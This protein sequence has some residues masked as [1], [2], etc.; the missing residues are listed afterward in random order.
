MAYSPA[1]IRGSRF[2]IRVRGYQTEAVE[3]FLAR[4]AA[5]Y[6][7]ALDAT[8]LVT[9][10]DHY[11]MGLSTFLRELRESAENEIRDAEREARR[12]TQQ[13][14]EK[15]AH[16]QD[17]AD[18]EAV[19]IRDS[20]TRAATT[21][22]AEAELFSQSAVSEAREVRERVH[23]EVARMRD[24]ATQECEA[25]SAS[26]RELA[27]KLLRDAESHAQELVERTQKEAERLHNDTMRQLAALQSY[28]RGSTERIHHMQTLLKRFTHLVQDAAPQAL[29]LEHDA[30]HIKDGKRFSFLE[31]R[32]V[33]LAT[34]ATL[35]TAPAQH[36]VDVFA[37]LLRDLGYMLN[38]VV[39]RK[40]RA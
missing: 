20:A 33:Q 19:A 2:P 29:A 18:E 28:E 16:I 31:P 12:A 39:A 22:L 32:E 7:L 9:Q 17:Q 23:L 11:L 34:I 5:D 6:Q 40:Q 24:R 37:A 30:V 26:A 15:V 14:V 4:L 21:L 8:S 1:E 27:A 3:S 36:T 10:T 35:M 25:A 13:T 38:Q